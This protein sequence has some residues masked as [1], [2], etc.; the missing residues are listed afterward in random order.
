MQRRMRDIGTPNDR[1]KNPFDPIVNP[2]LLMRSSYDDMHTVSIAHFAR[3]V[4]E[5]DMRASGVF[6]RT[7]LEMS[8]TPKHGKSEFYD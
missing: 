4:E 5:L 7:L 6:D 1:K 3:R 8:A 2:A